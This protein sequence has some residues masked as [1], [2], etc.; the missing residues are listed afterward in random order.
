[1]NDHYAMMQLT[2]LLLAGHATTTNTLD[3]H[4]DLETIKNMQ[5]MK[6]LKQHSAFRAW[7]LVC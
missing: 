3:N 1:M 5:Q 2:D 6:C 4:L 7:R